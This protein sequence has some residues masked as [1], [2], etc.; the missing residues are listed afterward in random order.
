M[1]SLKLAEA[2]SGCNLAK[3]ILFAKRHH[4]EKHEVRCCV[5]MNFYVYCKIIHCDHYLIITDNQNDLKLQFSNK[6]KESFWIF[7]F[8]FVLHMF[9][10]IQI[11]IVTF[12]YL[13]SE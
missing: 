8:H 1:E 4:H 13:E 12:Q 7:A 5:K 9:N 10:E 11:I 6:I 2:H 3:S